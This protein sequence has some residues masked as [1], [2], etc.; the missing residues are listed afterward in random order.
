MTEKS[1]EHDWQALGAAMK[2]SWTRE[3]A[4]AIKGR[5]EIRRMNESRRRTAKAAAFLLVLGGMGAIGL[6]MRSPTTASSDKPV[7]AE[8]ET[9]RPL[10]SPSPAHEPQVQALT[11]GT[12]FIVEEGVSKRHY[13]LI[14]GAVRF[15]TRKGDP[16]AMVVTVG[17]L[18][19]EDIGTIFTV[20]TL[21]HEQARVSVTEGRVRVTWPTGRRVLQAG[22]TGAFP[23][24]A[25]AVDQEKELE[26]ARQPDNQPHA[27][28]WR[29]LARQ[30]RY[31]EAF[32]IL[33]RYP[34]RVKSRVDDLM[35]AA[36]VMRLSGRPK[37]A[38]GYLEQVLK[39]HGRDPRAN[40]A[41]FTLGRVFLDAL[42]RPLQAARAF[43]TAGGGASPLAEEALAREVEAWSRAGEMTRAKRAALQYVNRYPKGPR[44]DVVRA[45]GGLNAP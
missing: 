8:L 18:K 39:R 45:F 5:I 32:K 23:P 17:N 35:L 20:E 21:P 36:D 2:T 25:Q 34:S 28:D 12:Q 1:P 24:S 38:V 26:R 40:L 14:D 37:Q 19:I 10:V 4:L 16:K 30:G 3:R 7:G 43:R 41:A 33:A 42:G 9:V 11:P 13:R 44:V 6:M 29:Q 27:D 15:E 31:Q 22:E